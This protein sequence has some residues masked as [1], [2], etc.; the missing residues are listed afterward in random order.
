V[1]STSSGASGAHACQAWTTAAA[2]AG[3]QTRWKTVVAGAVTV[4]NTREVT[5]PKWP[6]P[7]PRSAAEQRLVMMRVAFDDAT[8][9][10]DD[11]RP[12]QV[13]AGQA[14]LPAKDPE[15]TAE[16]EA[17]NSDASATQVLQIILSIF[18]KGGRWDA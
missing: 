12:E 18:K 16:R 15:P 7:A 6:P 5:T 2:A 13:V 14:V 11:L 8:V 9:R 1:A 17:G 3:G 4:R 10:Q